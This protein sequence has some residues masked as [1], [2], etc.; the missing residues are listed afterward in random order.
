[1]HQQAVAVRVEHSVEERLDFQ[2]QGVIFDIVEEAVNNARKHA[3]AKLI[4]V[5][6]MRQDEM[7]IIQIADN[8]VGF[9]VEKVNENYECA[10]QPRHGQHAR[11]RRTARRHARASKAPKGRGTVVT[12]ILP[13][14]PSEA[15]ASSNGF[16]RPRTKLALAAAARLERAE[17]RQSLSLS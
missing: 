2:Q 16:G 3:K 6:V 9:D 1:M 5:T 7:A 13:L 15:V 12:L 11:A 8:G 17:N 4:S 14:K 10:L